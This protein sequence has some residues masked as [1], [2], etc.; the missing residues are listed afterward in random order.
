MAAPDRLRYPLMTLVA[1]LPVTFLGSLAL[2]GGDWLVPETS[3]RLFT[4]LFALIA[5]I[6]LFGFLIGLIWT[7]G[8]VL[9][10]LIP[11]HERDSDEAISRLLSGR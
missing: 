9:V 8:V 10:F 7:L 2:I 3:F 6:G 11:G 5:T 4:L 1:S